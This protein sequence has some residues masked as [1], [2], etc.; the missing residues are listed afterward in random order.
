MVAMPPIATPSWIIGATTIPKMHTSSNCWWNSRGSQARN[1]SCGTC[2]TNSWWPSKTV[3]M[4]GPSSGARIRMVAAMAPEKIGRRCESGSKQDA[5]ST[6]SRASV[7]R[8]TTQRSP[9]DSAIRRLR[10]T[11]ACST[12]SIGPS[13]S[14]VSSASM[15]SPPRGSS[16][17]WGVP[18]ARRCARSRS[19][20]ASETS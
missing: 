3:R 4:T 15:L 17:M 19:I 20:A 9:V 13:A 16:S 7:S 10:C 11:T 14:F 18:S 8:A 1:V 12:S 5:A 6:R 2:G